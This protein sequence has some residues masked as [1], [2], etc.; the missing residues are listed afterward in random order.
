MKNPI[1][2]DFEFYENGKTILPLSIGM[3]KVDTGEELYLEWFIPWDLIPEDAWVM[4][5]VI[6]YMRHHGTAIGDIRRKLIQ[7]VGYRPTFVGWYCQYDMVALQQIWG[8]MMQYGE[9]TEMYGWPMYPLDLK[10]LA[11]IINVMPKYPNARL[12]MPRTGQLHNALDDARNIAKFYEM[13]R[14]WQDDHRPD[15]K[16]LP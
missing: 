7:F 12:E 6:P 13:L 3:V 10:P 5:N 16:M 14:A 11:E 9:A 8:T 2:F 4:K 15:H 1:A